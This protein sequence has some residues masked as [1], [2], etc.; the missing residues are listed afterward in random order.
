MDT[1]TIDVASTVDGSTAV[2]S[3]RS[4]D[5]TLDG[6]RHERIVVH[7]SAISGP[8]D[9]PLHRVGHGRIISVLS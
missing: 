7:G 9:R 6:I 4:L 8:L 2:V 5:W 3:H 1:G